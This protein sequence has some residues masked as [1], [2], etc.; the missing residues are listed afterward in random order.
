MLSPTNTET[1]PLIRL[2]VV[3]FA[4]A[5]GMTM[6]LM[7]IYAEAG[8][9][10]MILM[11]IFVEA[12]VILKWRSHRPEGSFTITETVLLRSP[13]VVIFTETAA[14]RQWRRINMNLNVPHETKKTG[15]MLVIIF[16]ETEAIVIARN[17]H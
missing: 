6:I 13:L 4:E 15:T 14:I 10:T 8:G 16:T 12:G 1:M 11:V 17:H 9:N 3:T 7:L 2:L 5:G